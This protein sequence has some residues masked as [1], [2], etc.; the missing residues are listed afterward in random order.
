MGHT[1]R[2]LTRPDP[3]RLPLALG[4]WPQHAPWRCPAPEAPKDPQPQH[5]PH[6]QHHTLTIAPCS[7]PQ[8]L[9]SNFVHDA[10]YEAGFTEAAGNLQQD[11]F[12]L[13]GI[14]GDPVLA[15]A[16]VGGTGSDEI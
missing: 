3:C 5:P 11:N 9:V 4:S 12:N 6:R 8:R 13:G 16:Q 1:T 15:E 2:P 10:L 14:A 7:T